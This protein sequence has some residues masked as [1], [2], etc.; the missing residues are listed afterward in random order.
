[1]D[2][3]DVEMVGAEDQKP[4]DPVIQAVSDEAVEHQLGQMFELQLNFPRKTFRLGTDGL[5]TIEQAKLRSA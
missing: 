3:D 4:V 2:D 5:T 1:M